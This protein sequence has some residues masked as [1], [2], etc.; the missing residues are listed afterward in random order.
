MVY[1]NGDLFMTLDHLHSHNGLRPNKWIQMV[2][3]LSSNKTGGLARVCIKWCKRNMFFNII[4][5]FFFLRDVLWQV[6]RR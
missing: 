5:Y 3:S 2:Y 4:V 6:E 1:D